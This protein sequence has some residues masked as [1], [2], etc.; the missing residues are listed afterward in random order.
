MLLADEGGIELHKEAGLLTSFFRRGSCGNHRDLAGL[1][2]LVYAG[3]ISA[4]G[5]GFDD[6]AMLGLTVFHN[7][8]R[9]FLELEPDDRVKPL[10]ARYDGLCMAL[11][12]LI[13]GQFDAL[14]QVLT[15]VVDQYVFDQQ[16][17]AGKRFAKPDSSVRYLDTAVVAIL[18]MAALRQVAVELP[19][20]GIISHY[21]GFVEVFTTT[22][23]REEEPPPEL[24]PASR[25][26][27]RDMGLDPDQI[28]A[29][30][31][32]QAE[33]AQHALEEAGLAAARAQHEG[34]PTA[35]ASH[36]EAA[37]EGSG[38]GSDEAP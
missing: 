15:M 3:A 28:E 23:V 35:P 24:D 9:P 11:I 21:R 20:T 38:E 26:M 10:L 7:A 14:G 22:P 2:A 8:R 13:Q 25:R 29:S 12:C 32:A 34:Q 6:E 1:G 33:A 36:A 19:E 5:R 31:L 17:K 4:M 30:M 37:V 18:A 16:R 27:L